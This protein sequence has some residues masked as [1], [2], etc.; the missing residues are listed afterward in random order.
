MHHM[1]VAFDDELFRRAHRPDLGHAAHIIAPQI[2]QHQMLGQFLLIRDQIGLIGAVFLGGGAAF[3]GACNRT[4][5]HLAI[6][7][8]HEDFRAGPD[9]LK[10][11]EVEEEQEGRRVCPAQRAVKREGRQF[12]ALRP[13][14]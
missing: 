4:N 9:H 8:P 7:Q 11:A 14:L 3:A 2:Q 12:K 13:A 5:C 6:A 1:A 10:S